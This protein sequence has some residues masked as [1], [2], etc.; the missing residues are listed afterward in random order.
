MIDAAGGRAHRFGASTG[1]ALAF[2]AAAAGLPVDRIAVHEVPYQVDDSM[3]S[4]WQAYRLEL[5]AL[6]HAGDR[7]QALRLFMRLAGSSEQDVA[8]PEAAPVWPRSGRWH[9]RRAT[10]RHA[11][12]T[13]R[14]PQT[15]LRWC[16][17]RCS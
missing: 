7:D 15:V 6:L 16:G 11:S 2:K 1:G 12:A 4:A 9:R 10:T 8:V 14:R 5:D 3:V 13:A 17:S